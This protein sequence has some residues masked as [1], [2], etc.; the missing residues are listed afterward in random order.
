[1]QTKTCAGWA[2]LAAHAQR[3][4]MLSASSVFRTP[5]LSRASLRCSHEKGRTELQRSGRV[6]NASERRSWVSVPFF[7][8]VPVQPLG[9]TF[10]CRWPSLQRPPWGQRKVAVVEIRVRRCKSPWL[11]MQVC[12]A[13]SYP[14]ISSR[15]S[16]HLVLGSEGSRKT[17]HRP[18]SL[19]WN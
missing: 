9:H 4:R 12:Y 8:G 13:F 18:D 14:K 15:S 6:A 5:C 1:M 2:W 10:I 16:A 7:F 17:H 3:K 11:P 19:S